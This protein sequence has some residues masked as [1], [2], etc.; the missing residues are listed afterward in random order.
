[1]IASTTTDASGNFGFTGLGPG[2]YRLHE[3]SQTGFI[4]TT[5][6]PTDITLT[7]GA[8]ITGVDFGNFQ[9]AK[10]S[11]LKF[12]DINS[13]G[14]QDTGEPG[15]PNFT[16]DL[17]NATT[18]AVITSTT[19]DAS[20]NFSF[21]GLG[22]GTYRIRDVQQAGFTET[23]V[24]PADITLTSG[25]N[26]TGIKFGNQGL[27]QIHGLKFEDLNA[28]GVR[29]ANEPGLAGF[30]IEL[31]SPA[32]GQVEFTTTTDATGAFSFTSIPAGTYRIREVRKNGFALTTPNPADV[33]LTAGADVTGILFGNAPTATSA[34]GGVGGGGPGVSGAPG[35]AGLEGRFVAVAAAVSDRLAAV[36]RRRHA[37]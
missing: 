2:T 32:T 21:T 28:N 17:L 20:G 14:V 12:E 30:T 22:P 26:I 4:Q 18:G 8:S 29:D 10:I 19:T 25:A 9:L 15:L 6:N 33:T 27:G 24:N 3:V 7:S 23:T 5:A 31:L 35:R 16:I 11:G 1:V 34:L 36:R 37:A 13:N